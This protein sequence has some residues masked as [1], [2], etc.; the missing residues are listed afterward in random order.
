MESIN[1]T[2]ELELQ[3]G[4]NV[5]RLRLQ[6]NITREDLSS[7]SGVSVTALK[8]LENGSGANLR[9]LIKV[10]RTLGKE[11]WLATLSPAATINPMQLLR[12]AGR[13]GQQRQRARTTRP[14]NQHGDN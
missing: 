13:R 11:G 4:E 7:Q 5:K 10:L 6:K 3:L 9:T 12:G 14:G 1:N 2:A 8:N